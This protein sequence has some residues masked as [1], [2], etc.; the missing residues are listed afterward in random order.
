M[1][2]K[3]ISAIVDFCRRLAL[4]VTLGMLLLAVGAG[5]FVATHFKINT[6]VNSL[7]ADNLGW[8]QI[9]KDIERAFP[10]KNDLLV[11]VIDGDSSAHA[12]QAAEKLAA[13]LSANTA[14]FHSVQRP[15]ALPLF[16]K[17][18]LLYL[19]MDELIDVTTKL[20]QMQPLLGTLAADPSLRGLF[21]TLGLF[22]DGIKLGEIKG[23]DVK[24]P[25]ERFATAIHA[26]L[27][28]TPTDLDW[29]SLMGQ[30]NGKFKQTRKFILTQPALDYGA[31]AP[32]EK[33]TAFIRSQV[34]QLQLTEDHGV[35][36]RLTGSV[37]LNDEEF[38]SVS[39]GM[40]IAGVLSALL[41]VIVLFIAL[42]SL[43]LIMPI[44]ITLLAG[45]SFTTAFALLTVQSFNLISIAFAVM[46]VG[47]A[48]DFGIQ[49]G[50]R[51]RG[52][53]H[54][55]P[56]FNRAMQQTAALIAMPL[57]LAAVTTALGFLCFTPTSYKGV[58]EL[59]LIAGS[60]M[61]IALLCNITLLPALI[62]LFRPGPEKEAVGFRW[63]RPLDRWLVNNRSDVLV[64]MSALAIAAS[65]VA[66]RVPFDFDPLNLKNPQA[67]SVS[68]LFDLINNPDTNPYQIQV[69]AKDLE[70][71]NTLAAKIG[72][73]V[74]ARRV[75]TLSSFVPE[76]QEEKL[77]LIGDTA[78][79]LMPS[80]Q[81]AIIQTPPTVTEI[82]EALL[83]T[84]RKLSAVSESF[85]PAAKLVEEL[86]LI[87]IRMQNEDQ[88]AFMTALTTSLLGGF[89]GQ[90]KQ[91]IDLLA[92]TP[93]S[94]ADLPDEL[95]RDWVAAD[96][97]ALL[98]IQ[99]AGN[100]RDPVVLRSFTEEVTKILPDA[101]GMMVS[102]LES[103]RTIV[104]AFAEAAALALL[105]IGLALLLA[106]RRLIDVLFTL[107]PLLLASV[108]T[109][110][111]CTLVGISINFANIIGLPLLLGIGVS[112]SIYFV[113]YWR[114]GLDKPLQSSM[115][116]AVLFSA[117]TTLVAFGSLSMSS[118]LGT[119]S[120][121]KILTMALVYCVLST[122]LLLPALLAKPIKSTNPLT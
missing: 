53:R 27:S 62:T 80:L 42:R 71:A 55:L 23:E 33:A 104:G 76:Q 52:V 112:Y 90:L 91:L 26:A 92:P 110:A 44:F 87:D 82:K 83:E 103:G 7:L 51:F 86:R 6:D 60:G 24:A 68:T 12:D 16:H 79:V 43:R 95:R 73:E 14:L 57:T 113:S 31:L 85:P 22:A 117:L 99:P 28:D 70:T 25:I 13:A 93:I 29:Q 118:H 84:A 5:W 97:R 35:R 105:A 100:P 39:E 116:R 64:L 34:Q 19:S 74:K 65:L 11:V 38:S 17:S 46:F 72:A 9:E 8:R 98:Q 45:L 59:G 109:L 106:L 61:I 36:V 120:M 32:G 4:P 30:D 15:D 48:V 58:A 37:A 88:D 47:I 122:W 41:V 77:M 50:V 121:G 78:T 102:I 40:G 67:E 94:F 81:P 108:L 101:S 54:D 63:A 119:A 75:M 56:D 111:T 49:F 89:P 114:N 66:L 69:L 10:Q 96:G 20:S 2:Q 21:V 115:A 107:M 3:T 1:L 18:G